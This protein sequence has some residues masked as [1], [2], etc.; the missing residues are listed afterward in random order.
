MPH[1]E[2]ASELI[3]QLE[4]AGIKNI[5]NG[6]TCWPADGNPLIGPDKNLKNY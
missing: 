3:P 2:R 4:S 5:V 6:P 1:I